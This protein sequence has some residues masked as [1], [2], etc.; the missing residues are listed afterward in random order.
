MYQDEAVPSNL[1][2]HAHVWQI[3]EP[4]LEGIAAMT[5][6]STRQ[7]GKLVDDPLRF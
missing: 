5:V 4:E 6:V 3:T 1:L 2:W 7:V